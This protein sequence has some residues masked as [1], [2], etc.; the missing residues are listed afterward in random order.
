MAL[1]GSQTF[2]VTR[3]DLIKASLQHIGAIGDGDT[4]SSTQLTEGSLLLNMLIKHLQADQIQL[5][6]RK[7]GYIFPVSD[8]SKT[9]LGA[10]GGNA[11]SAY[12]YITTT[13][14]STS[15]ASTITVS[16]I[17]GISSTDVIGIELS[18][19]DIQWNTVNGV[20]SGS[21]ITLTNVLTTSVNSGANVY[22]YTAANK[23][24]CPAE[25]T[26]AFRRRSSDNTDVPLVHISD[27]EYQQLAAKTE[28]GIPVQWYYDQTLGLGAS[29][30]PGNGDFYFWPRFQDGGYIIVI[31]FNKFLDDLDGATDNVEFPQLWFLPLMVGLAWLLAPKHGIPLRERQILMQEFMFLKQAAKDADQES[32]SLFI[33]LDNR[34]GIK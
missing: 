2:G 33:T 18:D 9:V 21:T 17:T 31:R 27:Q 28:E 29:G 34:M 11:A 26:D 7:T 22:S 32:G 13:A 24:T 12:T 1:S 15:G 20:P 19:S 5:W 8:V 23:L 3:D 4:P 10:E 14:A 16:S 25:I 6:I 30:Y